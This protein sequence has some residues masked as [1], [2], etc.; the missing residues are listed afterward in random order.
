MRGQNASTG[1]HCPQ[2]PVVTVCCYVLPKVASVVGRRRLVQIKEDV[3]FLEYLLWSGILLVRTSCPDIQHKGGIN[4]FSFVFD[5]A[6]DDLD[7]EIPG[8]LRVVSDR[9]SV[10]LAG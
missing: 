5:K 3:D 2:W 1:L 7:P 9:P 8:T 6:D 10:R 4:G